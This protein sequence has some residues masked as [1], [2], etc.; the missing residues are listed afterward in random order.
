MSN[1]TDPTTTTAADLPACP[2]WCDPRFCYVND[3][4]ARVHLEAP[5]QWTADGTEIQLYLV[6]PVD[7]F[8]PE[9]QTYLDVRV[10]SLEL[11]NCDAAVWLSLA[12]AQQLY[13]QLGARLH[14]AHQAAAG[15][16]S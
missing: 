15:G 8:D 10:T 13:D 14:A 1:S 7:K 2:G 3:V 16:A 11:E 9:L 4:G 6:A 5:R 12:G